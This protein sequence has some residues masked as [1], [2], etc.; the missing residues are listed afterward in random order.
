MPGMFNTTDCPLVPSHRPTLSHA[1]QSNTLG[2]SHALGNSNDL[3]MES[4]ARV[5]F[6]FGSS[7]DMDLVSWIDVALL[8]KIALVLGT[9]AFAASV[10]IDYQ[11]WLAFGALFYRSDWV[12][13]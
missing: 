5:V 4:F 10:F 2:F 8:L 9:L 6:A 3:L 11:L 1:G 13:R 7:T 12:R